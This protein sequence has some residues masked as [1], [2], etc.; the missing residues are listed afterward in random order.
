M[1]KCDFCR[2][3]K[4]KNGK[5]VCPYKQGKDYTSCSEAVEKMMKALAV[6]SVR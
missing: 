6:W 3:A 4:N 1:N 2:M 5:L